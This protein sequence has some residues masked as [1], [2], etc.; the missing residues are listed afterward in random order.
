MG[1]SVQMVDV[2]N[3]F[4][5]YFITQIP[6]MC[7][8]E[9]V[10]GSIELHHF[11]DA[12]EVCYGACTY[13]RAI[14]RRGQIHVTFFIIKNILAPVKPV[15]IPR[16]ELLAAVVASKL[17]CFVRSE[18]ECRDDEVDIL[19]RQYDRTRIYPE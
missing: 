12:S 7:H 11:C 10:D 14:N 1:A 19:D 4:G 15:T 16:L 9:F 3:L 8:D 18:L 2:A 5:P 17:D 6:Q 13:V